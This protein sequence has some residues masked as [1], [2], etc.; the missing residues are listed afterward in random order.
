MPRSDRASL[1][2]SVAVASVH[3]DLM[4]HSPADFPVVFGDETVDAALAEWLDTN[5]MELSVPE[6]LDTGGSGGKLVSAF[7]RYPDAERAGGWRIIKL[8]SPSRE[9]DPEPRNHKSALLSRVPA[10]SEFID[11]HLV[12]LAEK[13]WRLGDS[14]L[15]FQLPAGDGK[16]EMETLAGAGLP[17]RL[18]GLAGEIV[19]GVLGGWNPDDPAMS[20]IPAAKF[21]RDLLGRRLDTDAPLYEW[22]RERLGPE[23]ERLQWFRTADHNRP[24]PNPLSLTASCPLSECSVNAAYGRAH[25]DLHPGNIMI[26]V[27]ENAPAEDFTLIDLS[28]FH[29]RALLARDPVHLLLCLA[30]DTYLPHMSDF[31]RAELLTGLIGSDCDGPLIPQGLAD[32][33]GAVSQAMVGWGASRHINRDWG[34]QRY[35]SLQA[36]AL[37]FTAREHYSDRDRWWFFCLAAEAC[38]AYLDAMKIARPSHAPL[39]TPRP[40]GTAAAVP[41]AHSNEPVNAAATAAPSH[42]T[43]VPHQPSTTSETPETADGDPLLH[44]LDE[45]W[46]TFERPLEQLAPAGALEVK[47]EQMQSI[48][49]R[50][51]GFRTALGRLRP[52]ETTRSGVDEILR[53]LR[54]VADK[55]N[56][57]RNF[58]RP[59]ATLSMML[60][61]HPANQG[62]QGLVNALGDLLGEVRSTSFLLSQPASGPPQAT[63]PIRPA[64]SD[65]EVTW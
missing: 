16:E 21:V 31:A 65:A 6:P 42:R 7:V 37:M 53:L 30:A 61:Q 29:E 45:I 12:G 47:P 49:A 54:A 32:A 59:L 18:P 23:A 41:A 64:G 20:A 57:V 8:V 48:R 51:L 9:A 36:C 11:R 55:A 17:R 22:V 56:D 34:R 46:Y 52:T 13:P 40:A 2:Q 26:P 27:R 50:A 58:L 60:P 14:W 38:G 19:K 63:D 44:L 5:H 35:L 25:G 10:N 39:L 33:A 4:E 15:M 28:R 24:L 43:T 3:T 62:L 1:W